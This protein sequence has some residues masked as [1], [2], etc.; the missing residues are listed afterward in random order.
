MYFFVKVVKF[1][2][3][4]SGRGKKRFTYAFQLWRSL[5]SENHVFFAHDE[6]VQTRREADEPELEVQA[7][8]SQG[9]FSH[10]VAQ[11][12]GD[13]ILGGTEKSG[14]RVHSKNFVRTQMRREQTE[15]V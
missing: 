6:M 13:D 7:M 1:C 10:Y 11:G 2:F 15:L 5:H 12:V 14:F 9:S 4:S 3:T 8:G